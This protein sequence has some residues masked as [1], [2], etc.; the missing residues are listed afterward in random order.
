MIPMP[1]ALLKLG[2]RDMVRLSDARMSGTSFGACVLHVAPESHVGGPLALV[3]DGDIIAL[4]VA[5]RTLHLD[6]GDAE[7]ARRRAQWQRPPPHFARGFGALYQ[8]HIR[9]ANDG[10][11]FD[12]LEGVAATPDPEIH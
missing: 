11:D 10:C 8:N 4:D 9:Q 1:K 12:F 7:L 5:N 6:V 3:R 2:L